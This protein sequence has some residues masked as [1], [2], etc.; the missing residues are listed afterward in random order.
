MLVVPNG[1]KEKNN[2]KLHEA[3]LDV[4]KP[5]HRIIKVGKDH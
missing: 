3:Q 1:K 2:L 4:I 5:F